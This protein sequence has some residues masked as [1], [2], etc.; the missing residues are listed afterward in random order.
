MQRMIVPREYLECGGV[1]CPMCKSPNI[2]AGALDGEGSMSWSDV[3][4]GECGASWTDE[5]KL[6][7]ITNLLDGEGNAVSTEEAG[8]G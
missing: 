5:F 1:R 8:K 2:S 7:G 4:C 3:N 6:V